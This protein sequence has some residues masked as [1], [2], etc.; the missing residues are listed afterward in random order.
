MSY[1]LGLNQKGLS[2]AIRAFMDAS[3]P[4]LALPRHTLRDQISLAI[5]A[6]EQER[7][8]AASATP[9]DA[10]HDGKVR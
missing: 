5:Y 1:N 9:L 2:K 10:T 6:Y 3:T 8:A 4:R 7:L